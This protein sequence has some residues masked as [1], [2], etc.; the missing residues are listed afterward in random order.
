M[1]R[2]LVGIGALIAATAAS[3]E[4]ADE[5]AFAP[6]WRDGQTWTVVVRYPVPMKENVWSQPVEWRYRV[7]GPDA[8]GTLVVAIEEEGEDT[9][10]VSTRLSVT[11]ELTLSAAE[12]RRVLRGKD[13]IKTIRFETQAP[14]VTSGT[15]TPFDFPVFPLGVPSSSE[16]LVKEQVAGGLTARRTFVQEV[17][18]VEAVAELPGW[19]DLI[20]VEC[21]EG[22]EPLFRQVWHRGYPWPLFGENMNMQYRL[23]VER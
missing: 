12:T 4:A 19:E 22:D 21:A 23:V 1:Y 2:F 18:E 20:E 15:L 5:H 6:E 10:S 16:H 3:V 9:L 7:S 14:V 8:A 13:R 11:S 17:R